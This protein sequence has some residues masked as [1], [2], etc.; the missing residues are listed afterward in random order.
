VFLF[1]L[2]VT[3]QMW[4]GTIGLYE[5]SEPMGRNAIAH[6][7]GSVSLGLA[8]CF[9]AASSPRM[10]STASMSTGIVL[11]VI[12]T[13]GCILAI[14]IWTSALLAFAVKQLA[15]GWWIYKWYG[16]VGM[17]FAGAVYHAGQDVLRS[18]RRHLT[19]IVKDLDTLNGESFVLYLRPF[20][21]DALQESPQRRVLGLFPLFG[22]FV[23][24]RSEEERVAAALKRL[25]GPMV[26]VGKPGEVLPYVGASRLY[27]PLD[28]WQEPVRRLITQARMVVLAL[29]P[30]EGT[31]W[32]L[33]QALSSLPPERLI[34]LVPMSPDDYEQFRARVHADLNDHGVRVRPNGGIAT[35]VPALPEAISTSVIP[36]I[37][38][39]AIYFT[40]E[41][42]AVY[43]N[44]E[45]FARGFELCLDRLPWALRSGLRPA[46]RNLAAYEFECEPDR[47]PG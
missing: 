8:L 21:N 43:V 37:V 4:L 15:P 11:R 32:E 30:G 34:L 2:F 3:A 13:G 38:Q 36:S 44:L 19:K 31:M 33:R 14:S 27:L 39:G 41:W 40:P 22:L 25:L 9:Y 18:S 6:I 42:E 46:I 12:G 28:D 29:G 26:A 20:V 35:K 10:T 24:G 47:T 16:P 1:S 17:L 23:T 45:Q 5:L 7:L